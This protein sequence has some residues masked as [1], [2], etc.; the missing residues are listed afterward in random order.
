M[1]CGA[2]GCFVGFVRGGFLSCDAID[3]C[4]W[5]CG[6]VEAIDGGFFCEVVRGAGSGEGGEAIGGEVLHFGGFGGGAG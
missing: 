4:E 6:V 5:F 3:I 2:D 1:F